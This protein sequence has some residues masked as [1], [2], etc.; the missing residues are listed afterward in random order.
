MVAG[1]G[2]GYHR[3]QQA[4]I[5]KVQSRQSRQDGV[6]GCRRCRLPEEIK[7]LKYINITANSY[8]RIVEIPVKEGDRVK[9]GDLLLKQESI[10]S[11]AD[12]RST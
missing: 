5:V 6:S 9:R 1:G 10:Q 11:S 12:L 4:K 3:A 7:P 8:G 2:F